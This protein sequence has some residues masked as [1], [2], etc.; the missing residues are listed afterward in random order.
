MN[1]KEEL[2]L[3]KKHLKVT[4]QLAKKSLLEKTLKNLQMMTFYCKY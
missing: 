2:E 1:E 3:E 4:V